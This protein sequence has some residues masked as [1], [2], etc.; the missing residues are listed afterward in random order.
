M[1]GFDAKNCVLDQTEVNES[2]ESHIDKCVDPQR[3]Q[4]DQ[5]ALVTV[6][7]AVAGVNDGEDAKN[8]S[9]S[10]PK[11]THDQDYRKDIAVDD[12]LDCVCDACAS[13][14]DEERDC[15]AKGRAELPQSVGFGYDDALD[16]DWVC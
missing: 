13:E 3:S 12:G 1:S 4:E 8:E 15:C 11:T 14:D 10:F 7:A 6:E 2:T 16:H 5:N 9:R